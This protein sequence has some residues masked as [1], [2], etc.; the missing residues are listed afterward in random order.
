MQ[1]IS[2]AAMSMRLHAGACDVCRV[3]GDVCHV[4]GDIDAARAPTLV[5]AACG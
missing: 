2:S 4:T 1:N 5:D 3:T